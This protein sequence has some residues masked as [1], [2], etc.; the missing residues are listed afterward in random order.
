MSD[1]TVLRD[2][3]DAWHLCVLAGT[4]S[5]TAA[6][7]TEALALLLAITAATYGH[8]RPAATLTA[9]TTASALAAHLI[10]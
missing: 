3:A 6:A 1:T 9:A 7:L 10:H 5:P 2:V 4:T 8:H